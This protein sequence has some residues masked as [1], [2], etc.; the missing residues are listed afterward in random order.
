MK[1]GVLSVTLNIHTARVFHLCGISNRRQHCIAINKESSQG[2]SGDVTQQVS[3][4][5]N[6]PDTY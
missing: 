4:T 3:S 5:R 6:A 2:I 1:N